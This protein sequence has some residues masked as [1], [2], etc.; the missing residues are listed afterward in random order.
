MNQPLVSIIVPTLG[1]P[2]PL[3]ACLDSI[4]HTVHLPHEVLCVVVKDDEPTIRALAGR[5]VGTVIQ[6]TRGGAVQAMNMGFR[7]AHG[8]YLI[9]V[10]DDC[11]LLPHA[12]ANA[13]RFLQAPANAQA[14]K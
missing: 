5:D 12:I 7:A 6:P 9:Q 4:A 13:M 1:R 14:S 10:N 11:R 8:E 2:Q 3:A